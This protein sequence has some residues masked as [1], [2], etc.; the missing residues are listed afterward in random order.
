MSESRDY[1]FE[2]EDSEDTKVLV[3]KIEELSEDGSDSWEPRELASLAV[4]SGFVGSEDEYYKVLHEVGLE[5]A[6]KRVEEARESPDVELV[7]AV[8]STETIDENL[9]E[10]E[11]R[12]RDWRDDSME[13]ETALQSLEDSVDELESARSEIEEFIETRAWEVAP[14]LTNLSNPLLAARLISLAGGLEELAKMPSSTVQVLGAEDA[15]FRHLQSGTP[16]PK[17]GVIYLHPYVRNTAPEK[18]GRASRAVAGKLTIAA[19]IDYYSGD[20]REEL[21]EELDEKIEKIREE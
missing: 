10:L 6:R 1:W 18:R 16:P 21:A 11:E 12:V 3:E 15:L 13:S 20:L 17:H 14:N 19:R 9:N 8:R 5:L 4:E 7:H 2:G